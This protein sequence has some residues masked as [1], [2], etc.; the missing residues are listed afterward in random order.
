MRIRSTL[1]I[2][3]ALLCLSLWTAVRCPISAQ[4]PR[5]VILDGFIR[6]L[7]QRGQ[8]NGNILVAAGGEIIYERSIGLRSPAEGDSLDLRAQFRLAS[9]GKPFTAL[10]IIQLEEAGLLEY[11]DPVERYIPEWPYRGATI[12]NL[13]NHTSGVPG[14][15]EVTDEHWRP[16]LRANDTARVLGGNDQII[17]LIREYQ[18]DPLFEPG[19]EFGYSDTG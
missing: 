14:F 18:P 8:F 19:T 1:S 12:R 16:D 11:D 5:S 2:F 17:A 13:L 4:D 3:T 6:E 10:A 15:K 7:A 9:A